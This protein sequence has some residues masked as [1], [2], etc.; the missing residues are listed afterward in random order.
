MKKLLLLLVAICFS[1]ALVSCGGKPQSE[2]EIEIKTPERTSAPQPVSSVPSGPTADGNWLV[3]PRT[4]LAITSSLADY[5]QARTPIENRGQYAF[6]EQNSKTGVIDMAGNVVV[7]ADEDVHW[8]GLCGI[9][10]DGETKI[11]NA[12]GEVIGSGGHGLS[13]GFAYINKETGEVYYSDGPSLSKWSDLGLVTAD[14]II[15]EVVEFLPGTEADHDAPDGSYVKLGEAQAYVLLNADG[16]LLDNVHYEAIAPFSEG[17]FAGKMAGLWGYVDAYTG[18]QL[19]PFTFLETRPFKN[20]I[21]A[22][23]TET[24]WGYISLAG[25]EKTKMT[26]LDAATATDGKAWVKTKDGWGV[27]ALADWA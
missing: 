16:T 14:P 20:G 3:E 10:N 12:K 23:K 21:A 22:V 7:S 1:A 27:I 6:F 24:G 17:V 15:A 19:V 13:T 18:Q 25:N 9:T 26:F 5:S 4:D 8:C 2:Y 11:F